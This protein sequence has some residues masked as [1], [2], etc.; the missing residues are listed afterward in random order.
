[1]NIIALKDFFGPHLSRC[2][3]AAGRY[4][5]NLPPADRDDVLADALLSSWEDRAEFDPTKE[6]LEVWFEHKAKVA[7]QRLGRQTRR[8]VAEQ[9]N[10]LLSAPDDPAFAAEAAQTVE[11]LADGLPESQ[12]EALSRLAAGHSVRAVSIGL[13]LNRG[14]VRTLKKRLRRLQDIS[15][16]RSF[17]QPTARRTDSDNDLRGLAPIDHEIEKLLHRPT[18]ERADCPVCFRCSW[19]DGVLPVK[20]GEPRHADAE[21]RAAVRAIEE[22]KIEIANAQ[23]VEPQLVWCFFP[24]EE[25]EAA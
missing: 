21:I 22:R 16:R 19:F 7:R 6:A 18:T 25:A 23:R 3:A 5:R 4:L 1:M 8:H 13:H 12:R 11:S 20:Y 2:A 10:E 9:L 14:A 17:A 24:I 15:P